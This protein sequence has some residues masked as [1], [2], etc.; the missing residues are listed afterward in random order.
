MTRT[1][2]KELII[3]IDD[4]NIYPGEILT[5]WANTKSRADDREACQVEVRVNK[6]GVVEI[7]HNAEYPV[8]FDTFEHY[9]SL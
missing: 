5:I 3:D 1:P 7:F 9:Y 2:H 6:Y 4:I 8:T